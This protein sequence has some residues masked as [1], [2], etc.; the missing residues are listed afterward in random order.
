MVNPHIQLRD[1][2]LTALM[3]PSPATSPRAC[4]DPTVSLLMQLGA[5]GL[6]D[7]ALCTDSFSS[8]SGSLPGTD[9]ATDTGTDRGGSALG[10]EAS[11]GT[12]DYNTGTEG[13]GGRLSAS[14]GSRSVLSGLPV[15]TI[16]ELDLLMSSANMDDPGQFGSSAGLQSGSD[17]EA[18][19]D[20]SCSKGRVGS[21]KKVG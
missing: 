18:P 4:D 21:R 14:S 2:A 3:S 13:G 6:D 10:D 1:A 11:I 7:S 20:V 8:C 19:A 5:R 16:E 15:R 9:A 12:A 17:D